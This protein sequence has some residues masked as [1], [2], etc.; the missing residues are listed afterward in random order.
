MTINYISATTV[1]SGLFQPSYWK[2]QISYANYVLIQSNPN[3]LNLNYNSTLVNIN[4]N[5]YPTSTVPPFGNL[6]GISESA[7][8]GQWYISFIV[9]FSQYFLGGIANWLNFDGPY[10]AGVTGVT[11]SI[12]ITYEPQAFAPVYN[13]LP[14]TFYSPNYAKDGYRYLV[15]VSKAPANETIGTF[16]VVPRIDGSGYIDIQKI[17]STFRL[18]QSK[19]NAAALNIISKAIGGPTTTSC[20]CSS[21]AWRA[22]YKDFYTWYDEQEIT[23]T[24]E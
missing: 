13:P 3:A 9:N 1:S 24:N 17:L 5:I 23:L 15:T 12:T 4:D 14:F 8:G 11:N 20:F 19:G 21:T 2:F 18:A 10:T 7:A 6:W 22:F 16:K